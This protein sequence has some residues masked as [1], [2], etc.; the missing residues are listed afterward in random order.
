MSQI[1]R[2]LA[3]VSVMLLLTCSAVL[4]LHAQTSAASNTAPDA[5]LFTTYSF[6][7]NEQTLDWLVCG[8]TTSTEGCYASGSLGPFGKVGAMIEG[9]PTTSGNT[10]TRMIYVVDIAAGSGTGVTLSVYKKTDTVTSSSDTV[11]V[12]L[13]KTI[14]L[15][16]TGGSTAS[17][18]MAA[19]ATLLFI[20][21]DQN[22]QAVMVKK[23][24]LTVTQVGTYIIG[25]GVTAITTDKYGY[26]TVTQ[27]NFTSGVSGFTVFNAAGA[28]Q[29][30][31]G[32]ADFMLNT[33]TGVSTSAL[34]PATTHLSERLGVRPKG[35]TQPQ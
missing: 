4:S 13:G 34:P 32:G 16:L 27:G 22:Q 14:S 25:P 19:N 17:C 24:N 26:I 11:T 15:P 20:G 6:F 31:G 9:N 7:S 5:T 3:C 21:T 10:V 12:T 30:D 23:S 8:S 29:E 1:S 2:R 35:L 18:S 33:V 28:A